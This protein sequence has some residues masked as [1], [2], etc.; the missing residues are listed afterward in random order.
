MKEH[1]SED[2]MKTNPYIKHVISRDLFLNIYRRL[3][4]GIYGFDEKDPLFDQSRDK[5]TIDESSL[6]FKGRVKFK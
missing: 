6:K 5:L 4:Y 2:P 3:R 1:W